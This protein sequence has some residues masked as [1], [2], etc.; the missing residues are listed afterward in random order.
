MIGRR[1]PRSKRGAYGRGGVK[2]RGAL[3]SSKMGTTGGPSEV[4]CGSVSSGCVRNG[5][6]YWLLAGCNSAPPY[7]RG[8]SPVL[9]C[10]R[11]T[12]ARLNHPKD[13]R[14]RKLT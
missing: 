3:R 1:Q 4:V 5:E 9:G 8:T 7:M 2:R 11:H 6:W 14:R 13:V 10:L 12:R